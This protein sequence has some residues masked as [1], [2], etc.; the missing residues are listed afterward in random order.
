MYK[1]AL[2]QF[3]FPFGFE[4]IFGTSSIDDLVYFYFYFFDRLASKLQQNTVADCKQEPNTYLEEPADS[5]SS[6]FYYTPISR[7]V[8]YFL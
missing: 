2:R 4:V 1:K 3:D 8:I 5:L 6:I 7:Q